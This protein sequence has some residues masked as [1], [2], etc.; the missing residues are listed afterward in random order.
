MLNP[1]ELVNYIA[2]DEGHTVSEAAEHFNV[3]ESTIQ[4]NLAKIRKKD[5]PNHNPILAEKLKLAQAK[6]SLRGH[7]RGG[8]NGKRGRSLDVDSARM[9]AEAYL[10]GFTLRKISNLSGIPV[11]TLQETIRSINDLELQAR[12]DDYQKKSDKIIIDFEAFR[13]DPWKR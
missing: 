5:L 1:E 9:Y 6:V 2:E 10:S 11:S 8:E 3:S 7:K 12:I 4:K 13:G